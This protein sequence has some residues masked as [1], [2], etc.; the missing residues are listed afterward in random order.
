[1]IPIDIRQKLEAGA[2]IIISHSGG[3]DSQAMHQYVTRLKDQHQWTG[4]IIVVHC[5][6]G[7]MEHPESKRFAQME[8][9]R[10]GHKFKVLENV[11]NGERI[12]LFDDMRRRRATMD[13]QGKRDQPHFPSAAA[14]YCTKAHKEQT[15]DKWIRAAY[16][17]DANVVICMGLRAQESPARAK[18]PTS[19]ERESCAPT[20]SRF[21]DNWLP[22][23]DWTI[24]DVWE[25]IGYTLDEL[26]F[27][28]SKYRMLWDSKQRSIKT[29]ID[30][31]NDSIY[32]MENV[33]KAHVAYLRGNE[34][35]SCVFC[36]LASDNDWRIGKQHN[37]DLY[38]ALV[39]EEERTGFD[40]VH[41]RPLRDVDRRS[42]EK[43]GARKME[44]SA[45]SES[46]T[47]RRLWEDF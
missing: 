28:Q 44:A 21:V 36:V 29:L 46:V 30:H 43:W 17:K 7:I 19:W 42:E 41:K 11:V 25:E 5:D 35:V 45:A 12:D 24:S 32:N 34:R 33:F 15:V 38:Q 27:L 18:K 8:A 2:D 23:H 40:Y 26:A 47:Q 10:F 1:M 6:L 16:P 14:R 3:K 39:D 13:S 4:E 31:F 9:E 22:I 20:L 37:P